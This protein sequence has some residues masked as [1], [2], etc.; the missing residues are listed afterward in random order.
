MNTAAAPRYSLAT[1]W[2]IMAAVG[3]LYAFSFFHRV[4]VPG[5]LFNQIQGEFA[6]SAAVVTSL[7]AVLLY[8]YG[9]A[10]FFVGPLVDRLGGMATLLWGG[11][12]LCVGA[13][14]FPLA[15]DLPAL[16]AARAIVALGSSVMYLCVVKEIDRLFGAAHFAPILGVL[17][18]VGYLG[19][20]MATLPFAHAILAFGWRPAYLASGV[21]SVLAVAAAALLHRRTRAPASAESAGTSSG[22]Y[23]DVLR[24]R[25]HRPVIFT[26][27]IV[28]ANYFVMQSTLGKK[29]LE[30]HVGLGPTSASAFT[31]AMMFTLMAAVFLSTFISR[32]LGNR[33]KPLLVACAALSVAATAALLWG[34]AHPAVGSGLWL[35]AYVLLALSSGINPIITASVRELN[36]PGVVARAVGFANGMVYLAVALLANGAGLVLDHYRASARVLAGATLYPAQ[37]YRTL[38]LGLFFLSLAALAVSFFT[39]ETRGV[40]VSETPR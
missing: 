32:F 28:F 15:H 4:A 34:L 7:G 2:A 26:G 1:K 8:I 36:A 35:G 19:G 22:S 38:F 29:F 13:L 20:V 21:L 17:A 10:Q 24:N 14:L 30:D 12:L 16:F 18:V 40:Q 5:S 37:A 6:A 11:A 25:S 33:R 23:L 39:R 9:G 27:S 31:L 3:A